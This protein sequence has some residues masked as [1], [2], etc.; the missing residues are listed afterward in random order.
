MS[1][2]MTLPFDAFSFLPEA[3]RK[4]AT[5][6]VRD[7]LVLATATVVLTF[8]LELVSLPS[9]RGVIK[10][11]DGAW[12]YGMSIALNFVNHYVYGIPVYIASSAL[13]LRED[14]PETLFEFG[15]RTF[16]ILT[17]HSLL[18]YG[19]HRAFHSSPS[20]Y[21]HHR[22]HHRFNTH[23]PPVSANAVSAVEYLVAYIIPFAVGALLVRPH[24]SEMFAAVAIVSV[25]NL[26]IHTPRLEKLSER[27]WPVFVST[28]GHIEHHKRLTTNYAAPTLNWDWI[29]EQLKILVEK[30]AA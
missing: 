2:T 23:V 30:K 3:S 5:E 14:E 20:L 12:L 21:K 24:R 9:V 19:A 1:T 11:R 13:L 26:L 16:G 17:V 29:V 8:M 4:S 7:G 27:L 22:F 10:Q 18:Y 6:G 15:L 25:C 28:H